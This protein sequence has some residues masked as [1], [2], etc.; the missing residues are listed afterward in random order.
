VINPGPLD[1]GYAS[2][3]D[4]EHVRWRFPRARWGKPDDPAPVIAWLATDEAAWITGQVI[5]TEGGFRRW[6]Q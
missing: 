3:A 4:H 1:T 6:D 2:P 5:S